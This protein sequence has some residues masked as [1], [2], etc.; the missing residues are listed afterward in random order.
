MKGLRG[1]FRLGTLTLLALMLTVALALPSSAASTCSTA[2]MLNEVEIVSVMAKESP[3]T[4]SAQDLVNFDY[5]GDI[6]NGLLEIKFKDIPTDFDFDGY[7]IE[8]VPGDDDP[9]DSDE[10]GRCRLQVRFAD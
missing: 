10:P 2:Q 1:L 8:A 7:V 5:D 4:W 3:A 6:E 9:G